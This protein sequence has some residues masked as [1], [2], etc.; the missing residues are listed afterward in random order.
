MEIDIVVTNDLFI[1]FFLKNICF[2]DNAKRIEK[3]KK[4]TFSRHARSLLI[5]RPRVCKIFLKKRFSLSA[6]YK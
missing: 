6:K 1:P 4:L 3:K 2:V 5:V